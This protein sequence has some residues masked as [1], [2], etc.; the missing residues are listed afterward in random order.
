MAL[1]KCE[2]CGKEIS[3]QAATCIGCGHPV[4]KAAPA[5]E[6]KKKT[7]PVTWAVLAIIVVL[8]GWSFMR[9]ELPQ[10]PIEVQTREALMGSGG[11][12]IVKNTSDKALKVTVLLKNPT[13]NDQKSFNLSIAPSSA[14][15]IGHMEGWKVSPGDEIT[16]EGDGFQ[17]W[18]GSAR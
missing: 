12:L 18:S 4:T 8:V 11:V 17:G 15:E 6:A 9:E 1:I 3:E 2:A 13:S 7:S 14:S 16:I 10:L 5:P